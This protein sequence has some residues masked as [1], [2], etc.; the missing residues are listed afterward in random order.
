MNVA[1]NM[2]DMYLKVRTIN[3]DFPELQGDPNTLQAVEYY[4]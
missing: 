3:S 2:Q 4:F 1:Y